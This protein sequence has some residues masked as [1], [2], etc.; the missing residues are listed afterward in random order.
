[1][2]VTVHY[3][4]S[5]ADLSRVEDF[6]DRVI[7]LALA[8]GGNVRLWRSADARAHEGPVTVLAI[9]QATIQEMLALDPTASLEFV[10]LLCRLVSKRLREIDEKVVTWRIFAGEPDGGANAHTA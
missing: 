1:M 8:V 9:G 5:L 3:R 4:G 7:D 10:K 6:E 2:G